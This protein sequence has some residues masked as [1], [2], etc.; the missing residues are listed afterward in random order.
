M[1]DLKISLKAARVNAGMTQKDVAR[2]L[3]VSNKTVLNWETGVAKPALATIK[4]LSDIYKIPMENIFLPS[5][6][7]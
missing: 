6:T 3:R 4:S 7:H 2:E 1:S 5:D